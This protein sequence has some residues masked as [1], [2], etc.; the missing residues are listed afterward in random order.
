M[1]E[2][3]DTGGEWDVDTP[4]EDMEEASGSSEGSSGEVGDFWVEVLVGG[5]GNMPGGDES[6]PWGRGPMTGRGAGYCAGFNAPGFVRGY[7]GRGMGYGRG[8]GRGYDQG[9]PGRGFGGGRGRGMGRGMG[10]GYGY[11]E[12]DYYP[13]ETDYPAGPYRPEISR[14]YREPT[15]EEEKAHLEDIVKGMERELEDIRKR[16]EDLTKEE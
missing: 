3:W 9:G 7:A 15:P 4:G 11:Y 16:I 1:E 5:G 6:G 12:P 14:N 10:G 13:A 8:M 2:E